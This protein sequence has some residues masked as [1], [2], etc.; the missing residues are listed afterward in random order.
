[1][2]LDVLVVCPV[3]YPDSAFSDKELKV[4]RTERMEI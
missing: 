4:V 2:V 3:P 1:M